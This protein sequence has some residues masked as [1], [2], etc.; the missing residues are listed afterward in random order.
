VRISDLISFIRISGAQNTAEP[1]SADTWLALALKA[2]PRQDLVQWFPSGSVDPEWYFPA[3]LVG[4]AAVVAR[5]GSV[6]TIVTVE[7][8]RRFASAAAAIVTPPD[9]PPDRHAAFDMRQGASAAAAASVVPHEVALAVGVF[10]GAA[11]AQADTLRMLWT[12]NWPNAARLFFFAEAAY[13]AWDGAAIPPPDAAE[14]H[15]G[16]LQD[17]AGRR[18]FVIYRE[19]ASRLP[20]ARDA[21][22]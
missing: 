19:V 6:R 18:T 7:A 11:E 20:A 16:L 22:A 9:A 14:I 10:D 15:R 12:A 2:F 8:E 3:L 5:S 21:R 4:C 1:M 17:V 13:R